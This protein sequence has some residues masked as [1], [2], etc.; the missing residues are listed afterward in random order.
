[1]SKILVLGDGLL[2]SEIIKQ[3]GWDCISRKK[4]GFDIQAIETSY[5]SFGLN[6]YN[7]I[8]NC[9]AFTDTYST[10]KKLHWDIN[11]KSVVFLT[12]YCE[13]HNI[14]LV[15]ISTDYIY[16]NSK[17]CASETDVPVHL[18]T[19]YG[20]TKLL[21]DAY[22]Q[23]N[24]RNLIIRTSH[25][26]YPFPYKEAWDDQVTN[27]DYV[28][29]ISSLIIKLVNIDASGVYNV[30]TEEKTWYT[31]T[32]EEFNTKPINKPKLAPEDITMNI[33]KLTNA[34]KNINK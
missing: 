15:H 20:Y 28:N 5:H 16:A 24:D 14:K 21:G 26:P 6:N 9:I 2:G 3:T 22:V 4:D 30:G 17:T 25:K 13:Q 23:L 31:L 27:G 29:I 19:W 12:D 7:V 33:N 18:N 1:M 34:I 8:I 32:E 10:N 11:Y